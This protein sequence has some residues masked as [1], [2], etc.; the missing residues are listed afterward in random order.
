MATEAP[1]FPMVSQF[2]AESNTAGAKNR[3]FDL[4]FAFIGD[5]SFLGL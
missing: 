5:P 3:F 1:R 2:S 4:G